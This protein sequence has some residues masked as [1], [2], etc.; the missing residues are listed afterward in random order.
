MDL[1]IMWAAFYKYQ[2]MLE[3]MRED[4]LKQPPEV[5]DVPHVYGDNRIGG[6]LT[7]T[8][9]NW[10]GVPSEYAYQWTSD[11]EDVGTNNSY[12][13]T[14]DDDGHSISCVVTATNQAGSTEAPPSNE[15][16]VGDAEATQRAEAEYQEDAER[17]KEERTPALA[18]RN[19]QGRG[20]QT[21]TPQGREAHVEGTVS[22]TVEGRVSG[23]VEGHV[24]SDEEDEDGHE[25]GTMQ[26]GTRPGPHGTQGRGGRER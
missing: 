24:E 19:T 23:H 25:S 18:R 17:R 21:R 3:E 10:K 1:D 12:V 4:W 5:V 15:I 2:P 26:R 7:C 16:V 20:A 9:G 8:M 22:G 11:G 14:Q 6:S 13:I